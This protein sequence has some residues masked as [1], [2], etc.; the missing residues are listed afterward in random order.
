MVQTADLEL[1]GH[2]KDLTSEE[3]K[4]TIIGSATLLVSDNEKKKKVF[5]LLFDQA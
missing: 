1:S 5:G 4:K 2:A 3:E